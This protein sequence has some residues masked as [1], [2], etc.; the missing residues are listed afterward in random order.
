MD[1]GVE[2]SFENGCDHIDCA[3]ELSSNK[4]TAQIL[5]EGI[6][7][8]QSSNQAFYF[9]KDIQFADGKTI[10]ENLCFV[11]FFKKAERIAITKSSLLGSIFS[12]Y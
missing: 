2:M 3:E 10:N 7:Y 9:L 11:P 12:Y 4:D 1:D 5:P 8:A 6:E